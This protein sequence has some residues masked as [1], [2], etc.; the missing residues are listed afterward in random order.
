MALYK[1]TGGDNWTNNTNLGS[2]KPLSEWYGVKTTTYGSVRILE[3]D[4]N[5]L[6]GT[7]PPEL[8]NLAHL[9]QLSLCENP[10][11]GGVPDELSKLKMLERVYFNLSTLSGPLPL[12][13]TQ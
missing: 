6:T 5:N 2:D 7:L 13:F 8:G 12:C 1:A 11:T 3:L 4:G 10:I 9:T